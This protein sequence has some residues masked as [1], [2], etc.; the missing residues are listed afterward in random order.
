MTKTTKRAT[1]HLAA[2]A[3]ELP[4]LITGLDKEIQS[5]TETMAGLKKQGLVYASPFWK[6]DKSGQPKY[7][8]LLHTQRKGE[9][10]NR[11]YIGCDANRIA[12]ANAAIERA[13][14]YDDL[15]RQLTR[16]R[17][18]AEQ[19]ARVLADAKRVLT[20]KGSAW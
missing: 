15:D 14:K 4:D 17:S 2:L 11:E 19:G 10:R 20:G 12:R 7:F 18:Q 1:A 16:L 9:P 13:K 5:I 8:Y 6:R 3:D